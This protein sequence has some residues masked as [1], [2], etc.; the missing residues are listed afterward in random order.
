MD[1]KNS[2]DALQ[3]AQKTMT[4]MLVVIDQICKEHNI[5]YW[6]SAGTLLG[7]VRHNGFIPWDDDADIN[8]MREDYERFILLIEK[9]LPEPYKVQSAEHNT[10]GLHNWCKIA[11]MDDYEWIDWHGNWTKGLTID[12]FP[13]DYVSD[14]DKL[15]VIDKI[16]NRIASIRRPLR[17]TS[18]K[19]FLQTLINKMKIHRLHARFTKKTNTLTY[20]IETSYYGWTYFKVDEIFPLTE[21]LFEGHKLSI[22]TNS[23]KCLTREYGDYMQIPEESERVPHMKELRFSMK[24]K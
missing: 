1:T 7:A 6:L 21:G 15:S 3:S 24:N 12:I 17:V 5:Q 22:P 16:T 10:H 23:H 14:S 20:G 13:F 19:T 4:D 2:N 8:M 18:V 9:H 11:Y